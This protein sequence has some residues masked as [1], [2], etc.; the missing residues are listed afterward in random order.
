M[1]HYLKSSITAAWATCTIYTT[2]IKQKLSI[3][4]R[5]LAIEIVYNCVSFYS[6][7][8]ATNAVNAAVNGFF[9]TGGCSSLILY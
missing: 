4:K 3:F 2:L 6:K 9:V 5:I 8:K 7:K 1:W